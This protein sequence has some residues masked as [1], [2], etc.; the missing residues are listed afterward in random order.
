MSA[1]WAIRNSGT[2]DKLVLQLGILAALVHFAIAPGILALRNQH[3][4]AASRADIA[5]PAPASPGNAVPRGAH[6][7][8]RDVHIIDTA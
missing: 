3:S 1:N 4:G 2:N 6:L 7:R 8:I 5:L